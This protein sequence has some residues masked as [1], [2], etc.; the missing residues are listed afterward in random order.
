MNLTDEQKLDI[1]QKL[2]Y[3]VK[4]RETF[5]EVYDHILQSIDCLPGT[6]VYTDELFGQ[7]IETEFGGIEKL[8]QMEKDSAGYAFKAMQ[9]KHGQNMAYF[10]RWPTLVFTIAL[11]VAGYI[12]DKNPATHKSLMLVAMVTGVLPLSLIFLKKMRAKYIGWHTGIYIKPSV[13]EGYI[14]SVS[15]LSCNAVN[16]LSFVTRHFDY[17]GITTL[18][19]FV[20]YSIF[21]LSFFKLYRQEY[22]IQL[23]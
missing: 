8:K 19:V 13:K 1:Q 18:L 4:Y 6:G 9:K 16:I 10:F 11:T 23:I 15:S 12:I 14:F 2:N 7:I 5:D 3:A 20:A 21:V 17:Y 22:Q